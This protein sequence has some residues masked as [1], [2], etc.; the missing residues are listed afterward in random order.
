MLDVLHR[1]EDDL[2]DLLREGVDAWQSLDIN[3]EPPRV[4][5]LWRSYSCEGVGPARIATGE[6]V[7][8]YLHRIFPCAQALYHPHPWPSAIRIITGRYEMGLGFSETYQLPNIM[9]ADREV[10]RVILGPGNQYEMVNPA[11]WHYVKALGEPS[12]SV[13]VTLRP[14]EPPLFDHNLFGKAADLQPLTPE[15]KAELHAKFAEEYHYW[16]ANQ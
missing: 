2:P 10:A 5:R 4:Q 15:V 1:V 6:S 11:G 8:I 12:L 3:Y 9:R 16:R 14:W 13:M 7:R